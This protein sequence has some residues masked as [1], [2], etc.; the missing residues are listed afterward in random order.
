MLVCIAFASE[1]RG[2]LVAEVIIGLA[3]LWSGL[4]MALHHHFSR[5]IQFLIPCV[6]LDFVFMVCFIIAVVLTRKVATYDCRN[7]KDFW[8][9]YRL[10]TAIQ[11]EVQRHPPLAQLLCGIPQGSFALTILNM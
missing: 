2:D 11:E 1:Q 5:H 9:Y 4:A 8:Q 6:I 7:A 3:L 10:G